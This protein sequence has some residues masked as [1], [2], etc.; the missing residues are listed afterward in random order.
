MSAHHPIADVLAAPLGPDW[1]VEGLAERVLAAVAARGPAGAREAEEFVLDAE[2][3]TDRQSCRL[4]RPLLA[5]LAGKSAA[6]AGTSP[7]LYE[8]H[9]A[10]QRTGPESPV[11]IL[12]RFENRPGAVRLA[13]RRAVSP[14]RD[15]A[16][17]AGPHA[18]GADAEAAHPPTTASTSPPAP[19]TSST[20]R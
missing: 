13:L 11:W 7:N 19:P 15:A 14:P 18:V 1:T 20:P 12:G 9:L 3:I 10:F 16:P 8:G 17:T 4:I 6:E 2:T 5:C